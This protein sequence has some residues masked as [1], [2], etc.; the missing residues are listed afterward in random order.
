M[1]TKADLLK[2][3][4]IKIEDL[5]LDPNNP[6]FSKHLDEI[7]PLDKVA[8]EEIQAL[9]YAQMNDATNRFEIDEL[10]EAIMADGFIHVDK[11]FVKKTD[12]KYLIIEGNRRV[13]AIKKIFKDFSGEIT[14][15]LKQQITTIPCIVIDT[16][17]P[18]AENMIRKILGLRHHG[19]IL[20]WK[21]L[22][23]AFNLYQEYMVAYCEGD[24]EKAK[25]PNNFVYRPDV[26]RQVAA[27]FSVKFND[28][29]QKVKLY[30]V[31]LQLI[32]M[33]R[34]HQAVENSD[35]FSMI[36]ET[37]GRTALKTFFEYD[38]SRSV[39]SDDGVEK[40]LD[41]YFGLRGKQPAIT[42]ASAG[43]SNVRD[44]AYVVSEGTEE[45]IRRITVD[46]EKASVVK[47]E[48]ETKRSHRSLQNTLEL[49]LNEL[50][51][52]NLGEIGADGFAPNETE[53]IASIDKKMNQ[54]KRAAGLQDSN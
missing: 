33:S 22:P 52:I 5:L 34:R 10:V 41:V 12:K 54:L 28:V 8:N 15:D 13:T 50:N 11:I 24:I 26:A 31:Y 16:K 6:R 45:D 19:S 14:A 47:A 30:R 21:P 51:K 27:M 4:D 7:T 2:E 40:I 38:E 43:S 32:E 20:P 35:S 53:Y 37:L 49:V 29:R 25:D 9:A 48:V 39:F 18:G 23:A 42:E 17:E 46:R 1:A 36:E 3:K 44:F